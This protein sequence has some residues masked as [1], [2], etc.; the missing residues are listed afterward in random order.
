MQNIIVGTAGHVDHGKTC[1]IKALS[2]F[3]TDRLKEEKKRGITIDLGFANL[4]NDAGLHIGIIDVP[5]HEKFVKNMLAGIG[6]IDLVLMVIALDEGVM[7]QTTEHFE[8]L[9]MLHIRQGILVLTKSDLVDEEWAQLVEADV[10]DMVQGSFLEHAPV[11]RVSSFTG[12]NI[13][14][15]HDRI[16]QMVSDLGTRCEEPELFRLPVDRVFTTEGFGTVITGTL[17]EGMVQAGAEV[18]VYPRE[19]PIK[20][21]GIQSHGRKEDAAIAGQ[22]TALNLLNVK[23]EDLKRGDVL[24]Y[25]GSLVPSALVDVKLSIFQTSDRELKSG[26]RIHLNYGSAQTIA[27]AVLMD[28]DRI[29]CGE[30]AYAQLRFDE[31][32]VLKRNDRFIIRFLSP[33]ETFGGGIVLDA[34]PCKHRRGDPQV[35]ESLGIKE[36]GT[37]LEVMELMIKEESRNFPCAGR[38]AANMDLPKSRVVQLMGSLKE[39][40]RILILS[41]DS[42]IHMDYWKKISDYGEA[43]LAEYHRE[44]PI[45]EGMDKE[46]FKSRLSEQFRIKDIRKGA[47]LLAELVKRMVV[48]TQGAYVSGKDFSTTYSREL[49]GMLEQIG[50]LYARAGIEA[51]LT[52]EVADRFKDKNRARQIIAD[53][54]KNGRL[55]KLNPASYMDSRAYD[56]VL[57]DLKGYLAVHGEISLGEF[58]DLCGT[59]RKYAVQLLEFMDKKKITKMVGDKRVLIH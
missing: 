48:R 12:E 13:D 32:V 55:I 20:I 40:K 16:I 34:S 5:G 49:K 17:Q 29:A 26:D 51:P 8:I 7:P 25:P 38:I 10:E 1:L 50:T 47:A 15:L 18:M 58:R 59:S 37:D 41:D 22:R 2:G 9:K 4:P 56:Q 21:R 36:K 23:K 33:V 42:V 30:S 54:H 52:A 35:M 6:G 53:M 43:L 24:A 14:L 44:N 11:I 45:N 27:K 46:E 3:D 39:S 57:A 19:R 28:Q 31:P